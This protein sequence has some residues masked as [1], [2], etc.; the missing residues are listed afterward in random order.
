M[1]FGWAFRGGAAAPTNIIPRHSREGGNPLGLVDCC[2]VSV[3]FEIPLG[4][5]RSRG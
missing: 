5:P 4:S 1:G 2:E 3:Q